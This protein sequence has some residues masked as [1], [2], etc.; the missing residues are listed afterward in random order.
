MNCDG[1]YSCIK[2]YCERGLTPEQ[3]QE[4]EQH[5]R[6]CP[7]CGAF[8]KVAMEI[9]CREIA[10]LYEYVSGTMSAEQRA[11]FDRHFNICSECRDY[12]ESY[13]KTIHLSKVAFVEPVDAPPSEIPESLVLS[14]LKKRKVV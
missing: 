9:T 14:I 10:N 11:I 7:N 6:E 4:L 5:V 12:L 8:H 13:K 1:Y 3:R 2:D